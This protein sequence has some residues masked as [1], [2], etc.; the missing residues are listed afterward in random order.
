MEKFSRLERDLDIKVHKANISI[1][2]N[3]NQNII[4]QDNNKTV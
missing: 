2:Q 3:F 4:L 1:K